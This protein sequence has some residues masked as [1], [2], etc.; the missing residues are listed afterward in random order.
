MSGHL[1]LILLI[2]ILCLFIVQSLYIDRDWPRPRYFV[3]DLYLCVIKK[4][5]THQFLNNHKFSSTW[6]KNKQ[7]YE[8]RQHHEAGKWTISESSNLMIFYYRWMQQNNLSSWYDMEAQY[9]RTSYVPW[10]NYDC[11]KT[12]IIL[13]L[14]FFNANDLYNWISIEGILK[15]CY[16]AH[17]VIVYS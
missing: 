15:F 4:K 9:R 3:F 14:I 2:N 6:T 1:K 10:N 16:T 8:L 7:P 17:N 5:I 12:W 11:I 13:I